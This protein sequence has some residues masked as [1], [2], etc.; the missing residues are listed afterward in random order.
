VGIVVTIYPIYC[1]LSL[2]PTVEP[3]LYDVRFNRHV[4]SDRSNRSSR[5]HKR[6]PK[7]SQALVSSKV[8]DMIAQDVTKSHSKDSPSAKLIDSPPPPP[9]YGLYSRSH[10]HAF[11]AHKSAA[12]RFLKALVAAVLIC[13]L[14]NMFSGDI[15]AQVSPFALSFFMNDLSCT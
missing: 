10:D 11:S 13:F 8:D 7:R 15:G 1:P 9:P 3:T 5:V 14:F 2:R 12:K 4:V 6:V